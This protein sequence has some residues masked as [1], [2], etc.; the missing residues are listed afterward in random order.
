MNFLL[1]RVDNRLIHGQILE[2]WVPYVQASCLVVADDG[3]AGDFFRE[4]VIRMAV[5]RDI[6]VYVHSVDEIPRIY[7]YQENT[8]RKTILL[9][10]R[11]RDARKAFEGGFHFERLNIGNVYNDAGGVQCARSINLNDQDI[12]NLLELTQQGVQ[13]DLRCVPKDKPVDLFGILKKTKHG[14]PVTVQ[15]GRSVVS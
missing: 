7:S 13:V 2:A 15:K 4:S 8:G 12:Q 14:V 9:F 11:I 6:D 10:S 1:V 3:V 5:P